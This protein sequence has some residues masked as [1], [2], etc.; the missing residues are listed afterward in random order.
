MHNGFIDSV[1]L[2][3]VSLGHEEKVEK[4]NRS[5]ETFALKNNYL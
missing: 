3:M 2:Q 1:E 5:R 4:S